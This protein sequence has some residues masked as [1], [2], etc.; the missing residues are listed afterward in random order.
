M[1]AFWQVARSIGKSRAALMARA[2]VAG[3]V[4]E[5]V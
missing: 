4:Q 3:A 2:K 5:I 1:G